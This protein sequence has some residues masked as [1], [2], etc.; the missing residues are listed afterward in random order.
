MNS[1]NLYDLFTFDIRTGSNLE[2]QSYAR[3][4]KVANT[5]SVQATMDT[6][7]DFIDIRL[8]TIMI[9]HYCETNSSPSG[10]PRMPK[11]NMFLQLLWLQRS[12]IFT[13]IEVIKYRII[14][15]E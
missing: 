5:R 9:I 13:N 2:L 3:F 7:Y 12:V 14:S 10:H 11:F 4:A 6:T 8:G 1:S 15:T